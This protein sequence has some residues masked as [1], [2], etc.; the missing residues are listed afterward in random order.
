MT[1][2]KIDPELFAHLEEHSDGMSKFT[3]MS[4]IIFSFGGSTPGVSGLLRIWD[5]L[6][7]LGFHL[8]PILCALRIIQQRDALLR[9][10]NPF[11]RLASKG[12]FG[13]KGDLDSSVPD[14]VKVSVFRSSG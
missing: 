13:S 3:Q 7:V 11:N 12:I 14:T 10:Q 5:I 4:H 8:N 1:L 2:E 6:L 9:E